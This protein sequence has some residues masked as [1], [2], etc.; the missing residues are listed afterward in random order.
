[1]SQ[2][3]LT[4]LKAKAEIHPAAL[5]VGGTRQ[6]WKLCNVHQKLRR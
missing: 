2:S 4:E 5:G 1:M 3:M 6:M